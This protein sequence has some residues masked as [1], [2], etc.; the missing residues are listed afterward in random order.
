MLLG[1]SF[2]TVEAPPQ[3][4]LNLQPYPSLELLSLL[5]TKL[6]LIQLFQRLFSSPQLSNELS[7]ANGRA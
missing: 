6:S 3:N 4:A 7:L 5:C 2:A 1:I